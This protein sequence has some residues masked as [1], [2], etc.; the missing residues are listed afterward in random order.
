MTRDFLAPIR[1]KAQVN[2]PQPIEKTA[3]RLKLYT[4]APGTDIL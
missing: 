1:G 4:G 3:E 2:V